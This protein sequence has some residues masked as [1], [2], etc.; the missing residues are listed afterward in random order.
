MSAALCGTRNVALQAKGFIE[1][2]P[3][4]KDRA[5]AIHD[6]VRDKILF[7]FTWK[8]DGADAE[9]TLSKNRGH[10]TPK[11]ELFAQLLRESGFEDA[12]VVGVKIGNE[13][14][15]GLGN[16]PSTLH[17]TFTEVT[18]EGWHD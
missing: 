1:K 4:K 16:F 12:R 11:A 17:H 7:G 6:Y 13:V 10:C 2:Y 14:L 9:F 18:I 8:F 15:H 3:N 5:I